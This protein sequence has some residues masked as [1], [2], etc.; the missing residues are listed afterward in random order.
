LFINAVGSLLERGDNDPT[1]ANP[2]DA[3]LAEL[4]K[5]RWKRMYTEDRWAQMS[6]KTPDCFF[7]CQEQKRMY[8][9]YKRCGL[10][11]LEAA[12]RNETGTMQKLIEKA[13]VCNGGTLD[14]CA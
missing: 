10:E 5:A 9:Y 1:A 12:I 14:D 11:Q 13:H 6:W 4:E 3:R 7:S 2:E 8:Q